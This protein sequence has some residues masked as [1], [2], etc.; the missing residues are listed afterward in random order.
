MDVVK[1]YGAYA[2]ALD[3]EVRG[4]GELRVGVGERVDGLCE[5]ELAGAMF[6]SGAQPGALGVTITG[7]ILD[8]GVKGAAGGVIVRGEAKDGQYGCGFPIDGVVDFVA[9]AGEEV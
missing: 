8:E 5:T 4:F 6:D 7:K 2:L 9:A 3:D 1:G